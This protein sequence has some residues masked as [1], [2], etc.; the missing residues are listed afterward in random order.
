M[1]PDPGTSCPTGIPRIS[2]TTVRRADLFHRL[3][4]LAPL[5]VIHGLSGSG[6]TTLAADWAQRRA[7]LGDDVHWFNAADTADPT[8]ITHP[9]IGA[10][11]D[12]RQILV[13]D[14]A[15]YLTDTRVLTDL[16]VAL[17]SS[18]RLH[19][20]ICTRVRHELDRVA[21]DAQIETLTLTGRHLN[22]TAGQVGDFARSWGHY[23]DDAHARR[24]YDDIGGWLGALRRALDGAD[25]E[26]DPTGSRTVGSYIRDDILPQISDEDAATA[27][28]VVVATGHVVRPLL[29]RI[30]DPR[31]PAGHLP[32]SRSLD[33][34][35]DDLATHGFLEHRRTEGSPEWHYPNLLAAILTAALESTQPAL[36][37]H[38]HAMTATWLAA[39]PT[40]ETGRLG[41]LAVAHARA[42]GDWPLLARMWNEHGLCLTIHHP[43]QAYDAYY[44]LPDQVVAEHPELA[45]ASSVISA[46]GP[47]LDSWHRQALIANY[48]QAGWVIHAL[49][50]PPAS[51]DIL[52]TTAQM[53]AA[54]HHGEVFEAH[55]LAAEYADA[56]LRPRSS[57]ASLLHRAWFKLQWAITAFAAR[58]ASTAIRL[59]ASATHYARVA[60][61][62]AIVSAATAQL[63]LMNAIAGHTRT[64]SDFLAEHLETHTEN[65][66]IDH[67]VRAAGRITQG[68]LLLDQLD[69][70]ARDCF[71]I[72][73]ADNLEEWAVIAWARTQYELL[74][75][76]PVLAMTEVNRLTTLHHQSTHP[77]SSSQRVIDRCI[78]DLYLALGELN[79]AQRHIHD[80]GAH[81]LTLAVPRARLAFICGDDATARSIAA[82]HAWDPATMLRDRIDLLLIKAAC[83]YRMGDLRAA[84]LLTTRAA[85]LAADAETLIP[86]TALPESVCHELLALAGNPLDP[87]TVALVDAHRQPYP[88]RGQLVVLSRRET[89]VLHAMVEHETLADIADALV[90]SLNTVKKQAHAVHAKLGV[91]D[92]RS[93]LLQAHRLGLL[94]E[95]SARQNRFPDAG[96]SM[97]HSVRRIPRTCVV[98]DRQKAS[99]GAALLPPTP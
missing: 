72:T 4:V 95:Q 61:A 1:R 55:R 23:I 84:G 52:E 87:A 24:L 71:D 40:L 34:V 16:T 97:P 17:K 22:I 33:D 28:M 78:A 62:D 41:G 20:V 2:G 60:R 26:N 25:P 88:E 21:H 44:D 48:R 81:Q 94:P 50:L 91:H 93:A 32:G 68:I 45:L 63:A 27:I 70:A 96:G 3:D 80:A 12:A 86:Y 53:I 11:A 46:L 74:F 64:A 73:G 56:H 83:A 31:S 92:R 9:V 47:D 98:N 89:V 30:F 39:E 43:K 6:K 79:R 51:P 49:P 18:T 38:V 8:S 42:A 99:D 69:P 58:D 85:R 65:Q 14:D 59:L 7:D 75:G 15:H 37:R 76:D 10:A 77:E 82:T 67:P 5:T 13:I 57:E 90:V 54:R 29:A 35:L 66:W 19:V 36:A